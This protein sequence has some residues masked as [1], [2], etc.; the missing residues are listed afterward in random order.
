MRVIKRMCW[1][2][3]QLSLHNWHTLFVNVSKS[4]KVM[5]LIIYRSKQKL[6]V[7]TCNDISIQRIVTLNFIWTFRLIHIK[8]Q[9][10]DLKLSCK[11]VATMFV[12]SRTSHTHESRKFKARMPV[13][14][15]WV[16]CYWTRA[17]YKH[18]WKFPFVCFFLEV[19]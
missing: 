8:H 1:I 2:W 13:F 17:I 5:Y 3:G 15:S 14:F 18:V 12:Q 10:P 7:H 16:S 4:E 9:S 6:K 11:F 19:V